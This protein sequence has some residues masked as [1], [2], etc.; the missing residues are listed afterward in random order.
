M[1]RLQTANG[2]ADDLNG[3]R[4]RPA[5]MRTAEM[6]WQASPS[7]GVWRKRLE[8]IGPQEAGVVTSVVRY[9]PGSRF[10]AHA[11]PDGEEFLVLDGVL[12]DEHGQYAA[13]ANVLNPDGTRHAPSTE[14][15]CTL[16]VKLRQ[17]A[18]AGRPRQVQDTSAMDWEDGGA[19]GRRVKRLYRQ[20]GFPEEVRLVELAP[21]TQVDE[22]EH[23]G[24]EEVYVMSGELRD[25]AG[26]YPA[27]TWMR[28]P[29]GSR[30]APWSDGGCLLYVRVGGLPRV[31]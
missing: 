12:E 13:G 31:G 14:T 19:P 1:T 28:F 21:G 6:D 10:S 25:A 8:R 11:H 3:D 7:A 27:G 9:D 29:D 30:H 24:G 26:V 5:V 20:D 2:P 23:P 22:H 18:G 15:G 4:S 17:Y 16:F